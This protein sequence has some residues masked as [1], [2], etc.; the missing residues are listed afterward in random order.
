MAGNSPRHA[1]AVADGGQDASGQPDGLST[2]KMHDT[3]TALETS[4]G[5]DMEDS[6]K[7]SDE[8]G[9]E[10]SLGKTHSPNSTEANN[11]EDDHDVGKAMHAVLNAVSSRLIGKTAQHY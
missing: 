1:A 11:V 9:A 4:D 3:E 6:L 8:H 5:H 7:T 10:D 2:L